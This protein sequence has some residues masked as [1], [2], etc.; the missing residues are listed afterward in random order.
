MTYRPVIDRSAGIAIRPLPDLAPLNNPDTRQ[1]DMVDGRFLRLPA[2]TWLL[3]A[4]LRGRRMGHVVFGLTAPE[5]FSREVM[6]W[7]SDLSDFKRLMLWLL[8]WE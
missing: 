5:I 2:R 4:A 7:V 3:W 1:H 8:R 6:W